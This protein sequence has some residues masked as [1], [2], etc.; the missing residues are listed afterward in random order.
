MNY[1]RQGY[2]K[3]INPEKYIGNKNAIRYL[4]SYELTCDKFFD[5]NPSILKWSSEPMRIP[6]IK[7]TDGNVHYYLPDYW[8]QYKKRDGTILQEL[9]E[10]KPQKQTRKS[11]RK[12]PKQKLYEDITY[13]INLSKWQAAR[14]Y[15]KDRGWNFRIITEKDIF[16]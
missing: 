13:A 11:R 9:I 7:P 1:W 6:Y 16:R 15:A 14:K 5:T 10:V 8:I 12:N 2:Y 3:L 4:S